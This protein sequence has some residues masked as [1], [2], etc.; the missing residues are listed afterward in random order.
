MDEYRPCV[1]GT[2][3][4]AP[5]EEGGLAAPYEPEK[6][7]ESEWPWRDWNACS[8]PAGREKSRPS[9]RVMMRMPGFSGGGGGEA[10]ASEAAVRS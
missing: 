6:L 9:W 8:A 1:E 2:E 4:M 5:E 7:P 10:F 3:L